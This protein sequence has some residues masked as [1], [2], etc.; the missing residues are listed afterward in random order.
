MPFHEVALLV[1]K[2]AA[3]MRHALPNSSRAATDSVQGPLRYGL[4]GAG[5]AAQSHLREVLAQPLVTLVGIADPAPPSAWR[6][7]PEHRATRQFS[8]ARELLLQTAPHV[9]SICT[10]PRYHHELALLALR[11]NAHVICE[12][13]M[14]MTRRQA[15]EMEQ[16]RIASGRLGAVNFSYRNSPAFRFARHLV[17]RGDLGRVT[18][19]SAAYLQS[20]MSVAGMGWTWRHDA[21][22]AGFGVL[23][24]LGVHLI[25]GVRFVT[26]LEFE[27]VIAHCG[28]QVTTRLDGAGV[29]RQVT[30]ESH[31]TFMAE[32]THGA[33]AVFETTQLAPG[34]GN[35]FRIEISGQLGSL[36]IDCEHPDEIRLHT[37]AA[38]AKEAIWTTHLKA[39]PVPVE[40]VGRSEPTSPGAIIRAIRGDDV[41]Y[42]CFADGVSAQR[43]LSAL[44]RSVTS[45][46]WADTG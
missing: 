37:T 15:E 7:P 14:A 1:S 3:K 23:G 12:K 42:P 40:F 6:I 16:T 41:A 36:A 18:R 39:Q 25:D 24:D 30:T 27:R 28:T 33:L 45:G 11:A 2:A 20:F 46:T 32:L 29:P 44:E 21:S 38:P 8:S 13:P 43:V 5:S 17:A 31:A 19:V 22:V 34:Y 10:P 9:V 35:L 26:G 4:I